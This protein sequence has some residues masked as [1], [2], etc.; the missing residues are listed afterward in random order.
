MTRQEIRDLLA[1]EA[2]AGSGEEARAAARATSGFNAMRG[3]LGGTSWSVK[4][5]LFTLQH[6]DAGRADAK[7]RLAI[8]FPPPRA[9]TDP[10]P[11]LSKLIIDD[12]DQYIM[13]QLRVILA[14][15]SGLRHIVL[16][17]GAGHMPGLEQRLRAMG[18]QPAGPVRWRDAITSRP[19]AEG[20]SGRRAASTV[21]EY[22]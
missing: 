14:K 5:L 12:R 1:K 3:S 8:H 2:A 7:L 9:S 11:R 4:W 18:Y 10:N 16:F 6:S 17:Y 15:P 20:L 19:V 22:Q 21:A 13:D